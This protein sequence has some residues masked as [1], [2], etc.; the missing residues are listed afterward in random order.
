MLAISNITTNLKNLSKRTSQYKWKLLTAA[1]WRFFPTSLHY[2]T[3]QLGN[4][5]P[6][7]Q[8]VEEV[9][10]R[11]ESTNQCVSSP[12]IYVAGKQ[13]YDE[14]VLTTYF[15]WIEESQRVKRTNRLQPY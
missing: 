11:N 8:L 12:I 15:R 13:Y 1:F 10:V 3:L 4:Q 14:Y 5:M 6:N 7:T 9:C 2:A